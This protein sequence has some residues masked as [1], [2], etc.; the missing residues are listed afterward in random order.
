MNIEFKSDKN[1]LS[2][3][4]ILDTYIKRKIKFTSEL[5]A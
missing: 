2:K 5:N 4:G 1:E 3:L